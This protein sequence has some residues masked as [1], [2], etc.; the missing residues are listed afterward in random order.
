MNPHNEHITVMGLKRAIGLIIPAGFSACLNYAEAAE[1]KKTY[2]RPPFA[3]FSSQM[4]DALLGSSKYETPVW[5]LHN[6]LGLPE[7]L[8]ASFEQRT[9]YETMDSNFRKGSTGGDQQIAM[10]NDL[11]L[12]AQFT[13]HIE[14]LLP[15]NHVRPSNGQGPRGATS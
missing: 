9:R 13:G 3:P 10:Q 1:E 12:E 8:S 14:D 4:F 11:W 6:A 7:W 5:N 2:S 15:L